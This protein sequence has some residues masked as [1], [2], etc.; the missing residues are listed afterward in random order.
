MTTVTPAD[1]ATQIADYV[2]KVATRDGLF[3]SWMTGAADGG[4]NHDGVFPLTDLSGFTR[5]LE[6]PAKIMAQATTGFAARYA[7]KALMDAV[8]TYPAGTMVLVYGD[9][10]TANNG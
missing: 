6:S 5:Y 1:L 7:S 2:A 3:Y 10:T 8:T 4:V 9:T